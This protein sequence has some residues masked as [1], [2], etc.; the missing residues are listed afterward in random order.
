MRFRC[1]VVIVGF[2]ALLPAQEQDRSAQLAA[3]R[4]PPSA[5]PKYE[6]KPG[7]LLL[8]L[9]EPIHRVIWCVLDDTTLY[10]D[11]DSDGRLDAEKERF[12]PRVEK[13][14]DCFVAEQHYYRVGALQAAKESPAYPALILQVQKWNLE[15]EPPESLRET[16]ETLRVNP[17]RRNPF[18]TLK[19]TGKPEQFGM[20]EF[21]DSPATSTVLHFDGPT[22]WGLVENITRTRLTA[23]EEYDFRISL[24]TPGLGEWNFVYTKDEARKNL[25]PEIDV[26][27]GAD[28]TLKS[29]T[30]HWVLP[31]WC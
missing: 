8:A 24:G 23:G 12:T 22:T 10:V 16:M 25:R 11:Q 14:K 21:A 19:R 26:V 4:K 15:Y 31:E 6:S 7:Y 20:S 2:A 13:L 27:F 29:A 17:S 30:G 5:E 18:V 9:G 1:S 3:L 28:K